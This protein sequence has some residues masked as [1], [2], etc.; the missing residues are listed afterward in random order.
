MI[1]NRFKV[2]IFSG[3]LPEILV[4]GYPLY[5]YSERK[6]QAYDSPTTMLLHTH[7]LGYLNL[8]CSAS[9]TDRHRSYCTT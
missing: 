5:T 1:E 9:L 6:H 2:T 7:V 8:E 4:V 3:K